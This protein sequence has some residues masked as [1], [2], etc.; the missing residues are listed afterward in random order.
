MKSNNAPIHKSIHDFL[1]ILLREDHSLTPFQN[2]PLF[3]S[4]RNTKKPAVSNQ[5]PHLPASKVAK[6]RVKIIPKDS[7]SLKSIF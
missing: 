1:N 7:T 2:L 6:E 3:F 5:K 4:Q